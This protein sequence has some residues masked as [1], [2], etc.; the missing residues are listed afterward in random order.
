MMWKAA[1][2]SGTQ[3]CLG[4]LSH[5]LARAPR[6]RA[7]GPIGGGRAVLA[8]P[9]PARRRRCK[10]ACGATCSKWIGPL[11][12]G[13]PQIFDRSA[14]RAGRYTCHSSAP[15]AVLPIPKIPGAIRSRQRWRA[16][17]AHRRRM[18]AENARTV[19]VAGKT[20]VALHEKR[21]QCPFSAKS[22]KSTQF[23]NAVLTAHTLGTNSVAPRSPF[24]SL[25]LSPNLPRASAFASSAEMEIKTSA[26]VSVALAQRSRAWGSPQVSRVRP[27]Q[28]G[29]G[30]QT[31]GTGDWRRTGRR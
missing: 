30:R 16:G 21:G 29:D 27:C 11:R 20:I 1:H 12:P 15:T 6:A 5:S 19:N 23:R 22:T 25:S 2:A 28:P 31:T 24:P 26:R 13:C 8:S 3:S 7:N 18:A 17:S 4:A 10:F 9:T 14:S